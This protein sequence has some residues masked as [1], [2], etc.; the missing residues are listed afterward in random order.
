[1][2]GGSF[3][4]QKH[5]TIHRTHFWPTNNE[6]NIASVVN[7]MVISPTGTKNQVIPLSQMRK[8]S[9][10]G[11]RVSLPEVDW[12]G[13]G[14]TLILALQ[15]RCKFCTE[16]APFYRQLVEKQSSQSK[17]QLIA[18]FSEPVNN[19]KTYIESLGVGIDRIVQAPLSSIGVAGTPTILLVDSDGIVTDAWRGRLDGSR[20]REILARLQ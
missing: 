8:E 14:H 19:A 18:V 5:L 7:T 2:G 10:I 3:S 4:R 15:S 1:M 17:L 13:S 9:M 20:E 6:R 16:S 11:T 12:A